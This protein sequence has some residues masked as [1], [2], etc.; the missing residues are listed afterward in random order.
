MTRRNATKRFD[1]SKV[2]G[3]GAWV[4][5]RVM[6]IGDMLEAQKTKDSNMEFTLKMFKS[7]IVDWNWSDENGEPLPSPS[8][9]PEILHTLTQEEYQFLTE[10]F[11][12]S[13]TELKN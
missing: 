7:H 2:Q 10:V 11:R 12:G 9:E 4:E 8:D 5:A 13:E 6:T 1:A 3:D